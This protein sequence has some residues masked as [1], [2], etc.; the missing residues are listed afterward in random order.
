MSLELDIGRGTFDSAGNSAA[1]PPPNHV[2][3]PPGLGASAGRA[4]VREV[5]DG[6]EVEA[7]HD[8]PIVLL[9]SAT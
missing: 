2:A 4:H 9:S 3:H 1:G 8:S 7:G 5:H 6:V